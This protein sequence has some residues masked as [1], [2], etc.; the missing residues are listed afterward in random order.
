MSTADID[1]YL[2]PFKGQRVFNA[3]AYY[4]LTVGFKVQPQLVEG[5]KEM[6]ASFLNNDPNDDD[7]LEDFLTP[8]RSAI[9]KIK[10]LKITGH[11]PKEVSDF[12][13]SLADNVVNL[14]SVEF[15]RKFDPNYQVFQSPRIH[16]NVS[17][18]QLSTTSLS[19]RKYS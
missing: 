1:S 10:P 6:A 15:A 11:K 18:R 19:P 16:A 7:E 2:S 4:V 3:L 8:V 13:N 17:H 12:A 14:I 5:L 9:S